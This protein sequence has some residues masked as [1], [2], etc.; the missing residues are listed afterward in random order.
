LTG[1][2]IDLRKDRLTVGSDTCSYVVGATIRPAGFTSKVIQLPHLRAVLFGRGIIEIGLRGA[3]ALMLS[4]EVCTIA[5]AAEVLPLRLR[6]ITAEYAEGTGIEDH[7][8]VHIFEAVLAGYDAAQERMRLMT[9]YNYE[10]E[11][12]YRVDEFPPGAYGFVTMP[13]L[14]PEFALGAEVMRLPLDKRMIA[15]CRRARRVSPRTPCR[16]SSAAKC[17]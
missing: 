8:A 5:D 3:Y 9:L 6:E 12:G 10:G 13:V 14:P 1:F 16:R 17:S 4:P 2:V 11:D 7:R 15:G